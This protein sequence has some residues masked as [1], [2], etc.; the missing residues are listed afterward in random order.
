MVKKEKIKKKDKN[1]L[2]KL[3]SIFLYFCYEKN[4]N[5]S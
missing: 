5:Q 2:T 4:L 3:N 1:Q